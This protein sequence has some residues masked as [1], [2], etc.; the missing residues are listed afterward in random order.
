M[1]RHVDK[2]NEWIQNED[3]IIAEMSENEQMH[4][5]F[6]NIATKFETEINEMDALL[7]VGYSFVKLHEMTALDYTTVIQCT[8]Q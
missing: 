8:Q 5:M 2:Y 3:S 7:N 4:A 6:T 1:S